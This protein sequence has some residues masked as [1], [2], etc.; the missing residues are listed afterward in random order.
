MFGFISFKEIKVNT[1]EKLSCGCEKDTCTCDPVRCW[2]PIA[3]NKCPSNKVGGSS[4]N[5]INTIISIKEYRKK[6]DEKEAYKEGGF[7]SKQ[8]HKYYKLGIDAVISI[9]EQRKAL[10]DIGGGK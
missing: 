6:H 5:L 9:L 2:V 3:C 4:A 7:P 8:A 1:N 10:E